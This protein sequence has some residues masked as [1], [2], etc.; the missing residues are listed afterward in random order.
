MAELIENKLSRAG[1]TRYEISN[2]ARP[3]RQSRHNVNYWRGG[4]YLGF[5][6]G[7]HSYKRLDIDGVW[8]RRWSNEKNPG[9]YMAL[10]D[11]ANQAV[12]DREDIDR[13]RAAGEFM[14]LG[15]RMT[16]G[17]SVDAF[18]VRVGQSPVEYFPRIA[19][20]LEAEFMEEINGCLR[21]THKGMMV[22]N[23]IFVQFV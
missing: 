13:T 10:V 7:A 5:G 23:S 1:L 14:F 17:I 18:R 6:A 2:H 22:A 15:L 19:D 8:G 3:G 11:T 4:D 9:R 12:L 20:C 16:E 21:L